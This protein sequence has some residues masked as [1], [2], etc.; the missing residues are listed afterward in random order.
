MNV[1]RN[2]WGEA[3]R[4]AA[5]LMNRTPSRVLDFS[6]PIQKIHALLEKPE[7]SGL[8]PRVFGCTSY[9]HSD[10]GKLDPRA[11]KCMFIGYADH[12]KG[13]RCY[14]PIEDKVHITRD[15]TFHENV[16]YFDD[17]C[18]IPGETTEEVNTQKPTLEVY[19]DLRLF[20][21]NPEEGVQNNHEAQV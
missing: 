7:H 10:T 9:V 1:P 8:E 20:K 3:V 18:S 5:N 12:K 2:L 11:I 16:K 17:G 4:S 14:D 6:T 15:V 19:D 21:L 13:Y